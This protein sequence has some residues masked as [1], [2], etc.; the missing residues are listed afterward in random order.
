MNEDSPFSEMIGQLKHIAIAVTALSHGLVNTNELHK[1]VMNV[2]GF[3]DDML[4]EAFDHLV[5]DQLSTS[6]SVACRFCIEGRI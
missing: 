5:S 4:D 3:E 1:I 2:E 6:D